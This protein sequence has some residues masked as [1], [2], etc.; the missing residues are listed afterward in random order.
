[1]QEVTHRLGVHPL[2][3]INEIL[4]TESWWHNPKHGSQSGFS[5]SFPGGSHVV[6]ECW[7]WERE[8]FNVDYEM[9]MRPWAIWPAGISSLRWVVS[10]TLRP[11]YSERKKFSYVLEW[12][13]GVS[14][15][16]SGRNC[17]ET[18]SVPADNWT[19]V[20]RHYA[21]SRKVAGSIP[22][23]VIRFFNWPNPSS[24]TVALGVDSASNR[25]EY[26]KFSGGYWAVGAWG[27]QHNRHLWADYLE[28]VGTST[29]H[30]PM[31]LYS[32]LQG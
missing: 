13:M 14:Q 11:F 5:K 22:D 15:S 9:P 32:L 29:S 25:N 31:G 26:Q 19:L 30:N 8:Y 18:N 6:S 12:R 21:T 1:M 20:Q 24:R 4:A 16:R 3:L 7:K 23:E 2:S 28:N 10:F 27:W 17:K